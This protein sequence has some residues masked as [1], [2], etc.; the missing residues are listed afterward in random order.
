M[1]PYVAL[2]TFFLCNVC[3]LPNL[4]ASYALLSQTLIILVSSIARRSISSVLWLNIIYLVLL[5]FRL[6]LFIRNHCLTLLS[7][8][9]ILHCYSCGQYGC[10]VGKFYRF[11][12][13]VCI[14][15]HL[16]KLR[17][18]FDHGLIPVALFKFN[19]IPVGKHVVHLKTLLSVFQ[20]VFE[21]FYCSLCESHVLHLGE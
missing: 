6:S 2:D 12:V 5:G 10:V 15:C 19:C 20:E 8:Q 21:S 14:V 16:H 4:N 17:I 18:I 11:T 13:R 9:F 1:S 3:V 7:E